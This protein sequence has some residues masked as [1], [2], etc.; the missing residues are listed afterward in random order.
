MKKIWKGRAI[1]NSFSL[2][3][4][5]CFKFEETI[6]FSLVQWFSVLM[7]FFQCTTQIVRS[8]RILNSNCHRLLSTADLELDSK[9]SGYSSNFC[10]DLLDQQ[11]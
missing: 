7:D 4:K 11:P 8:L 2:D 9:A 5:C 3:K 1:Q 6:V 10:E